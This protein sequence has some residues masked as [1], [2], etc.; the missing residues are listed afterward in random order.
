MTCSNTRP[1]LRTIDYCLSSCV[2]ISSFFAVRF[3]RPNYTAE[4]KFYSEALVLLSKEELP[5]DC[6]D[7][8]PDEIPYLADNI[9]LVVDSTKS[10][11]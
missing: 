4:I 8:K 2:T 11:L 5:T 6:F 7:I 3:A 1:F 10:L 9:F